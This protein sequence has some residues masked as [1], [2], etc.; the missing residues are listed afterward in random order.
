MH[1]PD[2]PE[3]ATPSKLRGIRQALFLLAIVGRVGVGA[4]KHVLVAYCDNSSA[5]TIEA[6]AFQQ[7]TFWFDVKE[8]ELELDDPGDWYAGMTAR[9]LAEPDTPP[10]NARLM[11][12][13]ARQICA[14][15]T[16]TRYGQ[17]Q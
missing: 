7:F 2:T 10:A 11:E 15:S 4:L 12:V 5:K 14:R 17:L 9:L 16:V 13:A 6:S 8:H 3:E 1:L